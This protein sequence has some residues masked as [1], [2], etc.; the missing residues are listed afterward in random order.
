MQ[1]IF[2]EFRIRKPRSGSGVKRAYAETC[3]G[4]PLTQ[5]TRNTLT[6]VR[7]KACP[8]PLP[9]RRAVGAPNPNGCRQGQRPTKHCGVSGK[10]LSRLGMPQAA[11]QSPKSAGFLPVCPVKSTFS[12]LPCEFHPLNL[13]GIPLICSVRL[14]T[15][16]LE[17]RNII[18]HLMGKSSSEPYLTGTIETPRNI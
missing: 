16:F 10:R 8:P 18:S 15:S 9:S 2:M 17:L 5:A 6:P 7:G 13:P 14:C 4:Q 11:G 3:F 12:V 1:R